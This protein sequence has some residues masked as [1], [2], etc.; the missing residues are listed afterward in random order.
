M[1][2][3]VLCFCVAH[4]RQPVGSVE[5]SLNVNIYVRVLLIL[6]IFQMLGM[7]VSST[8]SNWALSSAAATTTM[9]TMM[10]MNRQITKLILE[11]SDL[12]DVFIGPKKSYICTRRFTFIHYQYTHFEITFP[13]FEKCHITHRFAHSLSSNR[14]HVCACVYLCV[15]VY[16]S[17]PKRW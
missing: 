17:N 14:R 4:W 10:M 6:Y 3:L 11:F 1:T 15:S 16:V 5:C 9:T 8:A 13:R 12:V 7:Y 2:S